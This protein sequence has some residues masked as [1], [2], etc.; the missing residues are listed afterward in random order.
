MSVYNPDRWVVVKIVSP[1]HGTCYKVL[2][3]WYGGYTGSDS[4]K[5]SSGNTAVSFD[6]ERYTFP[7]FSNS[8]Y[9]CHKNSYGMSNYTSS[10]YSG[11]VR[12][13]KA[14]QGTIEILPQDSDFTQ[15]FTNE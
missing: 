1:K 3:S 5:L 6:G 13:L 15:A 10:I 12:E 14:G 2:A 4:W 7:Q 11:W 8:T 9:K